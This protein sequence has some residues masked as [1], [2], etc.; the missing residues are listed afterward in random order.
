M[1]RETLVWTSLILVGILLM[2]I[3]VAVTGELPGRVYVKEVPVNVDAEHPEGTWR[4]HEPIRQRDYVEAM[5]A[6]SNQ[7]QMQ[8]SVPRSLGL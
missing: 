2:V 8:I 4:R 7:T 5:Q 3:R 1:K 6:D